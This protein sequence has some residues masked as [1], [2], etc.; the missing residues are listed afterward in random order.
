[1]KV[2]NVKG[3]SKWVNAMGDIFNV[4]LYKKRDT[5][6]DEEVVNIDAEKISSVKFKDNHKGSKK[7][8]KESQD[9]R[10]WNS[11]NN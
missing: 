9:Q 11:E 2:F 7:K 5:L 8:I 4:M 6:Q 10:I 1:M 3:N